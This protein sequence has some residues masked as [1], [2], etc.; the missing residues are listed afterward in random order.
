MTQFRT[1]VPILLLLFVSPAGYGW[2]RPAA[3]RAFG[4]YTSISGPISQLNYGPEFEL[5]G[6]L[7]GQDTLVTFPP[8]AGYAIAPFLEVGNTVKAEGYAAKMENGLKRFTPVDLQNVT[9]GKSFTI[10]LPREI[11][12]YAGAGTVTQFNYN[13]Q[14][15]PD[16]FVFGNGVLAKTPTAFSAILRSLL[17]PGAPVAISGYAHKTVTGRTVVDVQAINGEPINALAPAPPGV[18]R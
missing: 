9:T 16:G 11:S 1:V 13:D 8:N 4:L 17:H 2:S 7:I 14:G 12:I 10:P 5:N 6:F 15:E 3:S 18:V